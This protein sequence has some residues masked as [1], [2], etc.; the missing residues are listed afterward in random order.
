VL[1]KTTAPIHLR[2]ELVRVEADGGKIHIGTELIK[3]SVL[4]NDFRPAIQK[5]LRKFAALELP[6]RVV[7][8]AALHKI[9]V[10]RISVRNQESRWGSCSRKGT[11]PLNWRLIQFCWFQK[12]EFEYYDGC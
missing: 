8:L 11:I 9:C 6:Q 3:V 2:G 7:E 4:S 12:F 5:H 1:R 10:S